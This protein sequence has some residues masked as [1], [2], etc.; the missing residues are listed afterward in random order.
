MANEKTNKNE[1]YVELFIPKGFANDDPNEFIS[2][3]GKNYIVPRGKT[4]MVPPAVK[5]EYE[6]SQRA[7]AILEEKSEAF[8]ELTKT[9]IYSK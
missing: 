5:Y 1:N 8:V 9:P 4:S 2:V 3:F 7:K 6:R